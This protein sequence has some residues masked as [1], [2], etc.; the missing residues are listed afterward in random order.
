MDFEGFVGASYTAHSPTQ[1]RQTC[2]NLYLEVDE[3]QHGTAKAML[4]GTPGLR[5]LV[6]LPTPG[7]RGLLTA[8]NGRCF[9]VSGTGFYEL[10]A[11]GTA[12]LRGALLSTTGPVSMS[13][14]GL[15]LIIV[16]GTAAGYL[17]TFSTNAYAPIVSDAF[18]GAT[19]VAF[20]DQ[21]FVLHRQETQQIYVSGL[22]DGATYTGLEFASAES[23]PDPVVSL[24]VERREMLL[25]GSRSGELWFNSGNVDFP[26]APIQGTA[27]PYG[28]AAAHSL[29]ALGKFYWLGQDAHGTGMVLCLEG[30][31]P[32]RISTHA[33]EYALQGYARLD[34]AI[35]YTMQRE[36]H[37]WYVLNFPSANA[38]WAYDAATKLWCELADLDATTGL[39]MRH[40]VEHH[41]FAFG[42]HLVAG[43]QDGRI[44]VSDFDTFTNDGDPLVRER[45]APFLHQERKFLYHAVFE[46]DMQRGVGL[47]AAAVPGTD[48][49]VLLQWSDDAHTWSS[50]HWTSA[51]TLGAYLTRAVWRRLGRSRQRAYRVRIS[52][53]VRVALIAARIEAT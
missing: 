8:S 16:D 14:N 47:D 46:L 49:Q 53:P 37:S 48:P 32:E 22:L 41:A 50:E 18:Y 15:Q 24:E 38:T 26:F 29:R 27:F 33:L 20:F 3:S 51:G 2:V 39:F 52:D 42:L 35:G 6:T 10:L 7:V 4:V 12:V 19:R 28:C 34:D 5:R 23:Q 9:A 25:L 17:F 21:Y 30:Y 11:G 44:Y 43:A 36:G 1:D 31:Q 45:T 13:D 40:R